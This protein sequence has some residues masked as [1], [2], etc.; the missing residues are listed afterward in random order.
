MR[1]SIASNVLRDLAREECT[2][3]ELVC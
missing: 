2:F 1:E 3:V